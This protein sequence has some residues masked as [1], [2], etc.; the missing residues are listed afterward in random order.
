MSRV[1]VRV[2]VEAERLRNAAAGLHRDPAPDRSVQLSCLVGRVGPVNLTFG[3]KSGLGIGLTKLGKVS[4]EPVQ[5]RRAS[6]KSVD[7]HRGA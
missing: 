5:M 4:R 3:G 2:V 1:H 6:W 7:V